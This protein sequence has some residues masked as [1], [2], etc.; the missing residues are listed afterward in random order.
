[1]AAISALLIGLQVATSPI[2]L[3]Q[4]ELVS[5]THS[6][7]LAAVHGITWIDVPEI[8][9]GTVEVD[10][11]LSKGRG[12]TGLLFRASD[13]MNGEKF[14]LRHHQQGKP[15][16]WQY[17]PR[18][19][20]HQAYQIY[21]GDGFAGNTNVPQ[22]E[23]ITLTLAFSGDNAQVSVNGDVIATMDDLKRES[24]KG[25]IGFRT[26]FG[27]RSIRN[28]RVSEQVDLE[29]MKAADEDVAADP[30]LIQSW[31]VSQPFEA[32]QVQSF[33]QPEIIGPVVTVKASHRGIADLNTV[34]PI[35]DDKNTVLASIE[36]TSETKQKAELEFGFSDKAAVYVNGALAYRGADKFRSRDYRFLGTVG[37]YDT[38]TLDLNAG[39]NTISVGVSE[40]EGGWAIA[41][42]LLADETVKVVYD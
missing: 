27:E 20:G 37:F 30:N 41:G 24:I 15:D 28:I 23:W 32:A 25:R 11:K 10:L 34:A 18:Y 16:A 19:N 29:V 4:A 17:H 35:A 39:L 6:P 21:Q 33:M 7:E 3:N 26:L 31:R 9:N 38:V 1:M 5:I 40:K 12:F 22:D 14:Y 8:E 2:A 13:E 36:V 42:R